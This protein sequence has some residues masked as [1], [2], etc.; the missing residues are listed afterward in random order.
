V[1][2]PNPYCGPASVRGSHHGAA[3]GHRLAQEILLRTDDEAQL[4]IRLQR[5]DLPGEAI[6][7]LDVI[8][9][10]ERNGVAACERGTRIARRGAARI[11]LTDDPNGRVALQYRAGVVGRS[12]VDRDDLVRP[13]V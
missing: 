3:D 7:A 1:F 4:R 11:G 9:I 6:D 13:P 12:V 5:V 2:A 8:L 10:D